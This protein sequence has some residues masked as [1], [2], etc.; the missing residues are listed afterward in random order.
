MVVVRVVSTDLT[1]VFW[2]HINLLGRPNSLA[3]PNH[4]TVTQIE[5]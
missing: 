2:G 3:I 5:V 1:G 4:Q